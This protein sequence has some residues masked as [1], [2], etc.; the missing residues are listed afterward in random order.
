[1]CGNALSLEMSQNWGGNS[2]FRV[3]CGTQGPK[4]RVGELEGEPVMLKE[5]EIVEFGICK[6]TRDAGVSLWNEFEELCSL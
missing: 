3:L 1:M 2:V 4:F 5:G 6:E